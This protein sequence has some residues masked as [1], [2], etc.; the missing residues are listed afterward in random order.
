MSEKSSQADWQGV[1][2]S[3]KELGRKLKEHASDAQDAIKST[4]APLSGVAAQVGVVFKTGLAKLDETVSDPAIG[5]A[6][7]G[8]TGKFLDA[9]KVQLGATQPAE[10][11]AEK[12][13][14]AAEKPGD[15]NPEGQHNNP[16]AS[17]GA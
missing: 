7:R 3:V 1:G 17:P 8:A 4:S 2:D 5:A 13:E 15:E 14:P 6:A 11:S 10:S 9:L 12:P 16:R